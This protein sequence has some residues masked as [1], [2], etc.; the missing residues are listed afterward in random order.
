MAEAVRS[1][2]VTKVTQSVAQLVR[3]HSRR[4]SRGGLMKVE[5]KC[6]AIGKQPAWV[7]P[8][9]GGRSGIIHQSG[10]TR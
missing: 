1:I 8:V 2:G 5:R 3:W 4:A 9:S 7:K 10:Q 6:I